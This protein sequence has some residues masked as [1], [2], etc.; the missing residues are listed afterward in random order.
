MMKDQFD[1]R[2]MAFLHKRIEPFTIDTILEF[3]ETPLNSQNREALSGYLLYNQ[4][5]YVNL[6][7]DGRGEYW[8][9]RAGLFTGK[10]LLIRPSTQEVARGILI[11]GSRLVPFVNP[12]L[13][14]TSCRLFPDHAPFTVPPC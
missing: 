13:L 3:L 6:S 7:D 14:P 2:L 4:F 1:Q 5:A 12:A 11:P 10:K 8:I 9:T